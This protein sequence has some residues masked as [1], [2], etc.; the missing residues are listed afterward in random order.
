M[1]EKKG[2]IRKCIGERESESERNETKNSFDIQNGRG[3]TTKWYSNE[4]RKCSFRIYKC[5][6]AN[7]EL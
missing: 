7:S 2:D 3:A 6:N 4:M 5:M 1:M